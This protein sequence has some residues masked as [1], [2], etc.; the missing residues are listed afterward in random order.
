VLFNSTLAA[1]TSAFQIKASSRGFN[2]T[3]LL[4]EY[5]LLNSASTTAHPFYV[6]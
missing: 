3:A 6:F 1:N 5:S 4:D 2:C